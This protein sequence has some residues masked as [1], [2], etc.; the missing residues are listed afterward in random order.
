MPVPQTPKP[1]SI[2]YPEVVG[3]LNDNDV[4]SDMN[5]GCEKLGQAMTTILSKFDAVTKQMHTID[6]LRHSPP[7]K[8]R[9]D[10]IRKVRSRYNSL[11]Q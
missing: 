11:G 5:D 2:S 9:W 3:I 10:A 4:R 6:L 7:L 8:S 1:R